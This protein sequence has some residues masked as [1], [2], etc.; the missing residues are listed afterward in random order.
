VPEHPPSSVQAVLRAIDAVVAKT[1]IPA[2]VLDTVV[3]EFGT[4]GILALC[5]LYGLMRYMVVSMSRS[6]MGC[7]ARRS[8]ASMLMGVRPRYWTDGRSEIDRGR[9][10]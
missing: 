8:E 2:D 5:G 3:S 4:A 10:F 1:S 6:K 7:R 9:A